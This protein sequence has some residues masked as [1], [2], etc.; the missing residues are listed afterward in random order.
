MASTVASASPGTAHL[1]VIALKAILPAHDEGVRN[2]FAIL[3]ENR[4]DPEPKGRGVETGP[5]PSQR[6]HRLSKMKASLSQ[7]EA[8]WRSTYLT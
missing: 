4:P 7:I 6:K 8:R 1:D 3:G 5:S 2:L